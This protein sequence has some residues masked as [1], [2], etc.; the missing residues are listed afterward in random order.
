MLTTPL[1]EGVR[2]WNLTSNLAFV[3]LPSQRRLQ[4]HLKATDKLGPS[5]NVI[6]PFGHVWTVVTT[7]TI[8]LASRLYA[9]RARLGYM[10]HARALGYENRGYLDRSQVPGLVVP[11]N[12]WS[13]LQR[14]LRPLAHPLNIYIVE[15]S[16]A[17]GK[18]YNQATRTLETM[19]PKLWFGHTRGTQ[20]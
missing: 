16:I 19:Q 11:T 1:M 13:L 4:K 3:Q 15:E 18:L 6:W 10:G 14:E 2:K 20:G 5:V 7:C 9:S 17:L 8:L 12:P